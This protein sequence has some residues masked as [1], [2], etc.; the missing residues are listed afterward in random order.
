METQ[1]LI[2]GDSKIIQKIR[3]IWFR[4]KLVFNVVHESIFKAPTI[5]FIWI[6][7]LFLF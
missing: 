3:R 1:E 6:Y 7:Q 2:P 5:Q 4:D